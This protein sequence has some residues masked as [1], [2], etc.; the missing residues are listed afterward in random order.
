MTDTARV[1]TE[2]GKWSVFWALV[3][4]LV[5]WVL[6]GGLSFVLGGLSLSDDFNMGRLVG[7]IVLGLLIAAGEIAAI[8][9][10]V[11]SIGG[12]WQQTGRP[13]RTTAIVLG[14][15]GIGLGVLVSLL[16]VS[17]LI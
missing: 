7:R 3:S 12:A 1:S 15:V 11:T 17:F 5:G 8:Y 6:G 16:L 9:L 14:C 13:G 10:G 4:P 2:R